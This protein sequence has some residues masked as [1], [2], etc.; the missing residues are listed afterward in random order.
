MSKDLLTL[1]FSEKRSNIW[2]MKVMGNKMRKLIEKKL[3]GVGPVDN[4]P[5]TKKKMGGPYISVSFLHA[6][7]LSHKKEHHRHSI[8][9]RTF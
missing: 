1:V 2:A 8:S 4:R 9:K 6:G 3:D 7:L 5:S